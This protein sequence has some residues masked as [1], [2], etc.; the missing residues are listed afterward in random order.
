MTAPQPLTR[1][2]RAMLVA[3]SR[4]GPAGAGV[5]ELAHATRLSPGLVRTH[6]T[7]LAAR[8]MVADAVDESGARR[9]VISRHG[10]MVLA[11]AR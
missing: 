1:R 7:L 2:E 6:I 10:L 5:R 3:L 9:P 11:G 8:G 4:R